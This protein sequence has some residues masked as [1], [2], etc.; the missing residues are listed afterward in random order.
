MPPKAKFTKEELVAA[1]LEIVRTSGIDALTARSLGEKLGSSARPIFTV[2][3]SMEEVQNEVIA[4]ARSLYEKYE[5]DCMQCANPFK[6]SGV[7]YIR[8]A[9]EQPKLFQLLFMREKTDVPDRGTVLS[10][11]DNYYDRILQTVQTEYGFSYETS[12][13]I[14]LH[15]WIYSHGIASLIAT[16][17]CKFSEQAISEM[18]A[19]VGASIIRKYKAEE[20]K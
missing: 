19:D 17:V 3:N 4:A 2:F 10:L 1:A 16:N 15:L 8:F 7:G 9:S 20:K 12:R 6:G 18:L 13:E 11:I 14:Y 5:D